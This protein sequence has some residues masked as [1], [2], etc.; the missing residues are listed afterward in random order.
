MD[1]LWFLSFNSLQV[2][3]GKH[4]YRDYGL[5]LHGFALVFSF[6]QGVAGFSIYRTRGLA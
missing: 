2:T 5:A 6:F 1:L 3:Q 4:I